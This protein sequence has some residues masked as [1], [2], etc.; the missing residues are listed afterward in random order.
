MNRKGFTLIEIL[1]VIAIL[2]VL[3]G[4]VVPL[5]TTGQHEQNKLACIN[6]VRNI[7]GL[8][9][10]QVRY[11]TDGGPALILYLVKKGQIQGEDGLGT[12]F[13]PG[14][15]HESLAQAGGVDV[16]NDLGGDLGRLTSYAGRAMAV[17]GCRLS[18]GGPGAV[19]VCDDSE[20]H[21]D[22]RGYV[23]GLTGGA[24]KWRDKV[25]QWNLSRSAPVAPGETS[26][27]EELRCLA[28]E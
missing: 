21:H 14:D 17:E 5:I 18:K 12:L 1:V 23:V 25:D 27:V 6:N 28:A 15:V 19:L 8:L 2:G 13:C 20:D 22:N 10:G 16:Y 24:A 3:A 11:P 9:E 4:L 7:V 26:P